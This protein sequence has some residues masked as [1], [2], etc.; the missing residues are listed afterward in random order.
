MKPPSV[1]RLGALMLPALT[2]A[3]T[4]CSAPLTSSTSDSLPLVELTCPAPARQPKLPPA[5]AKRPQPASYLDDAAND[6]QEWQQTLSSS[7][8]R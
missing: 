3:I 8:S 5:L 7:A 6:M 2:L 1:R 4:A